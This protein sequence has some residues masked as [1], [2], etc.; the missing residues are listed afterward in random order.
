MMILKTLRLKN[1]KISGIFLG[2]LETKFK[3]YT[4]AIQKD[5]ILLF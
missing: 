4:F 5:N 3:F 1:R 2:Y